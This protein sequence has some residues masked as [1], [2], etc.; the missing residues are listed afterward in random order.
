MRPTRTR[1]QVSRTARPRMRAS[2]LG[3]PQQQRS[4]P[5]GVRTARTRQCPI[6]REVDP[7]FGYRRL[8]ISFP[9]V[10]P[11][12]GSVTP[13]TLRSGAQFRLDPP[14]YFDL[15]SEEYTAD[16]NEVKSV[17]EVNSPSRTAEQSQIAAILVRA[18]CAGMESHHQGCLSPA[19]SRSLGKCPTLWPGEFRIGG[20]LHRPL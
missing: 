10:L 17:G 15:T 1:S 5:C 3:R 6:R 19:G 12:W 13:F 14:E 4:S 16:Y 2:L 20:C 18:V 9:R 8:P 7:E 11:G